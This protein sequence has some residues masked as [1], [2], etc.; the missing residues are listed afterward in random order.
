M[1]LDN[2]QLIENLN[3]TIL[4]CNKCIDL[5]KTRNRIVCGYGD[6]HAKVLFIGE[7]P[8]R[9]GADITG[10]PFTRDRSGKLLQKML[11]TIGM[12]LDNIESDNPNLIDAYITNIVRCN[13]RGER[14]TNRSPTSEEI[15]NCSN[16]LEKEIH[17]LETKV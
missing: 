3:H 17:I 16:F 14:D 1:Y 11:R 4:N 2:H 6:F 8:G 5:T 9:L 15:S 13:P 12:N 7:A 10:V